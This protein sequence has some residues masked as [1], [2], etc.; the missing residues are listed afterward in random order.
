MSSVSVDS[1]MMR[2][3]SV[4]QAITPIEKTQLRPNFLRSDMC[5][6]KIVNTGSSKIPTSEIRPKMSGRDTLVTFVALHWPSISY[7]AGR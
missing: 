5:S 6:R 3:M 7:G 1:S 4:A 2:A